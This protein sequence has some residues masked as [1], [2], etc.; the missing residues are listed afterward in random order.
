VNIY[1]VLLISCLASMVLAAEMAK[2]RGL[3]PLPWFL[4]AALIGPLALPLLY[5]RKAVT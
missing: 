4:L 2:R 3:K 5:F 1:W